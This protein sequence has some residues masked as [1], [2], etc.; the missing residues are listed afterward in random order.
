MQ[1]PF[2]VALRLGALVLSGCQGQ[3]AVPKNQPPPF[4][5]TTLALGAVDDTAILDGIKLL[6]GEW[7][8]SRGG[9]IS[10]RDKPVP[11]DSL[12]SIDIIV[13][14]ARYLGELVDAGVLAT[15]P[16]DAVI[17]PRPI[18]PEVGESGRRGADRAA[19]AVEDS[20]RYTD[21]APAYRE[22]VSRYGPDRVALPCGGTALVLVYR[23]DAFQREANRA[24]AGAAGLTLEKP[25]ATWK[26]FDALA[27]F[28]HGR[29]WNGDGA[30][31]YG[32]VLP[33]GS[34]PEEVGDAL[35]LARAAGLGQHR[36]H[37]SFM[38]DSSDALTPRI[39]TPPFV[40][41]LSGLVA[42]KAFGPPGMEK[43]NAVAA[44]ESFRTGKVAMLIDRADRALAWSHG[45]RLGVAPLPE[46][47][48]V[49]E[50]IRKEWQSAS[51]PNAARYLPAGGGWVIGVSRQL[52]GSQ[53]EAA[54]DLVKYLTGPESLDR[55]R[56]ERSFPMLPVRISQM[57]L[58]LPDPTAAPDVDSNLWGDAV[59][60]H[61]A[62]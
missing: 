61:A 42:L 18:E 36:D 4:Q 33:L 54:L 62:G 29:D 43:F 35:F 23:E 44:R 5:G 39:D 6:R 34:D 10:I 47:D 38:F 31:D 57:N 7:E 2:S 60:R 11:L 17:P 30:P 20:F 1:K 41:A 13:F 51:P 12:A 53:Y 59:R 24:A 27:R 55:L 14:P 15:I 52:S 22:Q 56:A 25:P 9:S 49:Y 21:I 32:V 3:S 45:K 48:R 19:E 58:G 40:E 8:A 50:P 16:N 28:F 26:D 37:Y 46:S